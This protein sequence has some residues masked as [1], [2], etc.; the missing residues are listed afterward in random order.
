M[1]L[2]VALD[3]L[4]E[5]EAVCMAR[6]L[7]AD[8]D[9]L[10]IGTSFTKEFGVS[11]MERMRRECQDVCLLADIKIVDEAAYESKL[12]YEAG[13]DIITVMGCS[14]IATLRIV[15]SCAKQ[16]GRRYL[17]D[18]MQADATMLDKVQEFDDA[19]FCIHLASDA[20]G[21]I[22]SDAVNIKKALPQNCITA[23]AGG[24]REEHLPALE[25]AGIDI[26]IIGSAITKANDPKGALQ[27]MKARCA[28]L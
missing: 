8:V 26:A 1:K 20:Q 3:R 17:I 14:D 15:Q 19:I 13:A 7:S 12:Y 18:L 5:D 21:D 25:Q 23:A 4:H 2:Q 10:E 28:T 11:F 22:V 24:I 6:L 27:E 16:Y 9:I